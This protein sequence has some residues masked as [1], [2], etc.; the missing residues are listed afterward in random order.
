MAGTYDKLKILEEYTQELYMVADKQF[1]TIL[2]AET[3]GTITSMSRPKDGDYFQKVYWGSETDLVKLEAPN[4]QGSAAEKE[5]AR[6]SQID[7]R[8]GATSDK[9]KWQRIALRWGGLPDNEIATRAAQRIVDLMLK[10]R[11]EAVV[12]SLVA[13]FARGMLTSG[14]DTEVEKV[15]QSDPGTTVDATK[16][17][18]MGKI[19]EAKNKLSDDY[20]QITGV[21]MHGGAFGQMNL[22][23]LTQY[24]ELFSG[25]YGRNFVT[26]TSEG[27]P[28]YVTDNPALTYVTNNV[29]KYRTLLLKPD[30]ASIFEQNDFDSN[31]EGDNDKTWIE[32]SYKAESSFNIGIDGFTWANVANRF[33]KLGSTNLPANLTGLKS[34]TG[35]L[36]N[37]ASWARVGVAESR[38]IDF[39][40]LPGVMLVTQ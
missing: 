4:V 39:K 38:G 37:P 14:K 30:A 6:I 26:R 17:I 36:D 40:N 35:V 7:I 13:C 31:I 5:L 32:R 16:Q 27:L 20:M 19:I 21:I 18:D 8:C 25:M 1:R 2:N 34:D 23:N 12:A 10:K 28:I 11:V 33:P 3:G 15:I 29:S 9:V 22:R 24:S